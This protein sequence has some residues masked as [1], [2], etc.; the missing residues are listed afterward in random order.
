[1]EDIL[2]PQLIGQFFHPYWVS[3]Y[4]DL[5]SREPSLPDPLPWVRAQVAKNKK[6]IGR[7][8][9]L[10]RALVDA[11]DVGVDGVLSDIPNLSSTGAQND[12]YLPIQQTYLPERHYFTIA[13]PEEY[14][15][16]QSVLNDA[17]TATT[18]L[19]D[20]T[21][22]KPLRLTFD[23]G[24]LASKTATIEVVLVTPSGARKTLTK[25]LL[26]NNCLRALVDSME[27]PSG[28][29]YAYTPRQRE[30]LRAV[31]TY[32]KDGETGEY[33]VLCYGAAVGFTKPLQKEFKERA[34]VRPGVTY[35]LRKGIYEYETMRR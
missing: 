9:I 30:R 3:R 8:P 19:I 12:H 11:M 32:P 18:I 26:P 6:R 17:R 34:P 29:E 33:Q 7:L 25:D 4:L 21:E 16:A 14:P 5:R 15:A 20:K 27:L 23:C 35:L 2:N 24:I 1:V 31:V 28:V 13:E 22:D 10:Y